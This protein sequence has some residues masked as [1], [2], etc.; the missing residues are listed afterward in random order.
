MR[1]KKQLY[2]FLFAALFIL[3]SFAGCGREFDASGY[4]KAILDNSYKHDPSAFLEQE[5]GSEEEAEQ[6]F[7]E[8]IDTNIAALTESA[9]VSQEQEQSFREIFERIYSKADYTVGEAEKQEDDSYVVTVT[10]RPMTLFADTQSQLE[11]Q[12]EE[13]TNSYM[14]QIAAGGEVPDEETLTGEIM[15]LYMGILQDAAD[16][17]NYGEENSCQVRIQ[18]DGNVY[19]PN[20]DDLMTLENGI[21]GVGV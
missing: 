21:L 17:I 15:A 10:Y 4:L 12:T 2:L 20:T 1:K 16:N 8:G 5:I 19:T 3:L 14:D 6:L 11:E 9:P 13:L 18:L 7:Q